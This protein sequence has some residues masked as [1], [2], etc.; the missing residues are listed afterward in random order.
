[1]QADAILAR[2]NRHAAEAK[3]HRVKAAEYEARALEKEADAKAAMADYYQARL[4]A[5]EYRP[6]HIVYDYTYCPPLAPVA[7]PL[8][9]DDIRF[10]QFDPLNPPPGFKAEVWAA[11]CEKLRAVS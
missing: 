1:M 9:A 5:E 4:D 8:G 6:V 3:R 10:A 2:A 11:A 7:D